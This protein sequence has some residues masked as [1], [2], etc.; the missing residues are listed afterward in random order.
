LDLGTEHVR[1]RI[2]QNEPK[3]KS[4]K[5]G[6]WRHC[7]PV[8]LRATGLIREE[9]LK[10]DLSAL[11]LPKG[12]TLEVN[13]GTMPSLSPRRSRRQLAVCLT[14]KGYRDGFE[15][16]NKKVIISASDG[17]FF[18]GKGKTASFTV[19]TQLVPA[20]F[21]KRYKR[22]LM[23]L[24]SALLALLLLLWLIIGFMRPHA[25]PDNLQV[26]WGQKI[27]RLERNSMPVSEVPGSSR[28]F[29]RNA[30]LWIGGRKCFLQ[31]GWPARAR[32]EA[33]SRRGISL[34]ADSSDVSLER[35]NKFDNDKRDSLSS[36]AGVSVGDIYK[37]N[38]LYLRLKL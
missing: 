12:L 34:I 18:A 22:L 29:Y 1:L 14:A 23:I 15:T 36:G 11:K 25:F 27:E 9:K 4:F 16:K 8:E 19:D 13:D 26:C 33:T 3:S 32:F 31:S 5:K 10:L 7:Q 21:W 38:D 17:T 35:I 2:D 24:G 30:Q 6:Q 28:G 37:I 20:T